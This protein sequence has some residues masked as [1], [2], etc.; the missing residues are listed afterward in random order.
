MKINN[1]LPVAL[2]FTASLIFYNA[3]ALSQEESNRFAQLEALLT[4]QNW[5]EADRETIAV[6]LN[7]SQNLSC[8]NLRAMN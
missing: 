2:A 5:V 3:Q 1:P 8:P 4:A 7:N 6:I